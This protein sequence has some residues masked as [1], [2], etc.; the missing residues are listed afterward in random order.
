MT[1][2]CNSKMFWIIILISIIIIVILVILNHIKLYNITKYDCGGEY[3]KLTMP[4]NKLTIKLYYTNWCGYSVRFLP[5]W[6]KA[7]EYFAQDNKY[8]TF[9][10]Y[11]CDKSIDICKNAGIRGYPSI[12]IFKNNVKIDFPE[13]SP[14]N[15]ETLKD[16]IESNLY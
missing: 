2:F 15:Y 7:K 9:E 4:K 3:E 11:D 10:E 16:F 8:V 6:K 5:D 1:E 13:N 12:V 14:R